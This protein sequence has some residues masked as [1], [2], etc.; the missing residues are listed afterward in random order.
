MTA[1]TKAAAALLLLLAGFASGWWLG[2]GRMEGKWSA[3]KAAIAQAQDTAIIQRVTENQ[4]LI[5]KYAADNAAITKAKN[6][7][8]AAVRSSLAVS[9][10]RGAG[11]CARPA[12]APEASPTGGS[13]AASAPS[14]LFRPDIDRD[15]RATMMEME[16]V[17]ATARACQSFVR[18]TQ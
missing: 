8:I 1:Y 11:I 15:L 2:A 7:E 10:R 14:E 18:S 13:D 5:D 16:E 4:A 3:S 6:E 9:L 17:A 12:S